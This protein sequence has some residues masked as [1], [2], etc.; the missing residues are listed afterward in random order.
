MRLVFL[1]TGDIGLPVLEALLN[2]Q[3]HELVAV[4]SQPD[5]PVGRKQ[6]L[7]PPQI[8]VRALEAGILV[9]QPQRIRFAIEEL[10]A[11]NADVFVV[12]AY[13]QILPRTVL[14]LPKVACLN[15]HASLLPRHR[16]AAPI[17]AAIRDGDAESGV[18]IMW[19]DEGLDTGDILLEKRLPIRPDHTGGILHDELAAMAPSALLEA[20]SLLSKGEAP[21]IAQ[22]QSKAT[23]TGKLEREHGRL[24]WSKSAV[25]LERLIRAFNPW[26]GTFTMLPT[27]D[28]QMVQLKVHGARIVENGE[29]CPIGGTILDADGKWLVSCGSGVLELTEIQLEGRKRMTAGDFLRGHPVAVGTVLK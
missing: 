4:V 29:A 9:L 6:I 24:D 27:T 10:A 7:T 25:E 19:M 12:I 22:D 14:D 2:S 13:G 18:T 1:G 15:I 3:D 8:K 20:L 23:H 28:E 17:Q 5:K 16:G 26:P 21:R 11:L